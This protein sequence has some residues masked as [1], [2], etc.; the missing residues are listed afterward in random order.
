MLRRWQSSSLS[1]PKTAW[2]SQSE[3]HWTTLN[4]NYT[5]HLKL[6]TD[7]LLNL[8]AFLFTLLLVKK[9][10]Y[11][12]LCWS[13]HRAFFWKKPPA[14][15]DGSCTSDRKQMSEKHP[16][17]RRADEW[18]V[19]LSGGKN[20]SKLVHTFRWLTFNPPSVIQPRSV[21]WR[22]SSSS[23]RRNEPRWPCVFENVPCPFLWQT[24]PHS[25]R[26]VIQ[27]WRKIK[28]RRL[29]LWKRESLGEE[30]E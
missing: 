24:G 1:G 16:R 7:V 5:E 4:T 18:S 30:K 10:Y 29:L 15:P 20:V 28:S 11:S 6:N 12:S 21:C 14:Q 25:L 3:S 2:L 27:K 17:T 8:N 19:S 13:T 9:F 26:A 23:L 22:L